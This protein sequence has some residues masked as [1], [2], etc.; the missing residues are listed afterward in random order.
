MTP[1]MAQYLGVFLDEG[2]EQ[3][4]LLEASILTLERGDHSPETL[5]VLFRAA[6]TLKGSSRAMG[7]L[8]VGDLTHEMENVLDDLRHGALSVST[9]IVNVLLECLDALAALVAR[10]AAT[11]ADTGLDDCDIPALVARL[12]ALRQSDGADRPPA[13]NSGGVR[14]DGAGAFVLTDYVQASL[15]DAQAAG[16]TA[17]RIAVTLSA[18]CLMKSV[19]VFMVL[20]AL[21]PLGAV[22]ASHPGEEALDAEEF[23]AGFTLL[24]ASASPLGEIEAALSTISEIDAV[25]VTAWE[26]EAHHLA[27]QG[28]PAA[29]GFGEAVPAAVSLPAPPV[30][31]G[32]REARNERSREVGVPPTVRRSG[33]TW[34]GWT[35]CSTWSA[36]W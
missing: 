32:A 7:F 27:S 18:D 34:R 2:Q 16:L 24:L 36:N 8:A 22:L 28:P 33:W 19:R 4:S 5:Q 30:A 15:R 13:P 26:Q 3:L 1:D 14:E 25:T 10:V 9:P 17:Y 6:H 29:G 11:G 35:I 21:E 31:G 12:G 23:E 20:G